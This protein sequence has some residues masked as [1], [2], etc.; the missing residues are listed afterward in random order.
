M[1]R[2]MN[3]KKFLEEY[4]YEVEKDF[5]INGIPASWAASTDGKPAHRFWDDE[6]DKAELHLFSDQKSDDI[7]NLTLSH[8]GRLIAGSNGTTVGIF[9][10]ETKKHCMQFKGLVLPCVKLRFSPIAMDSGGYLLAIES[11]DRREQKYD[12]LFLELDRDG[13][14]TNE[15]DMIDVDELLQ[16]SLDPILSGLNHSFGVASTSPL[17]GPVREGYTHA[18][19]QLAAGLESRD[20]SHVPGRTSSFGSSPF[21]MD[22]RFFLYL[23]QNQTTQSG[24]R[25]LA[26]LPKVVVYDMINRRQ[27]HVLDGHEDAIMW[28]AFSP[29]SRY[30]ATAAWDGTFRIFGV[31]TGD[32]KHVIGPT[33]G[34][35]WSGA[36]SPDSK[37]LLVS[38]MSNQESDDSGAFVAVYSAETAQQVNRFKPEQRCRDWC[39]TVAWSNRGEITIVSGSNQL[40]V[41][42]PF[43]NKTVSSFRLKVED[44][45]MKSFASASDI[46]WVNEGEIL[47]V[48]TGDGTIE[49]WN[50]MENIKWRLQR[51]K[52]F[53]IE[54]SIGA[55]RWVMEDRTLRT[56][57]RDGFMRSYKI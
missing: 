40:W 38:G 41:W 56:F 9:N 54:Q 22:G 5:D 2:S 3:K 26:E 51:P 44:W 30:I 33:E 7:G 18:L 13:H 42:E 48:S 53:G 55:V 49:I 57:S 19:Q 46:Q 16:K 34:Q 21:S 1:S 47:V 27:R 28:T 14:R 25:P 6:D 11:S 15:P 36:W 35:C 8:D 31:F 23:I 45:I 24:P 12:V 39:R 52:G 17:L 43:E 32:C 50:R 29:D 37:H 20:L 4:T 10:L